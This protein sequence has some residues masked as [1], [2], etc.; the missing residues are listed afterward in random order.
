MK[1]LRLITPY[2]VLIVGSAICGYIIGNQ[3]NYPDVI[4]SYSTKQCKEVIYADGT[5][6]DCNNI[7]KKYNFYWGE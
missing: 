1:T 2:I 4:Y 3:L 5:K 7:P 6:G